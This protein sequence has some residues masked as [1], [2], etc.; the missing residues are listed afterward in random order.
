MRETRL[1]A[2][3]R[4]PDQR[5]RP[6]GEGCLF[7]LD[8]EGVFFSVA[9]QELYVFNTPATLLWCCVEEGL[10][11]DAII[12]CYCDAF[13]L[14]R[15]EAQDHVMLVLDQWWG[16]GYIE[17][18]E[19]GGNP[20]SSF[21]TALARVLGNDAM[22][23]AFARAPEET[24]RRLRLKGADLAA[25]LALDV[26][27]LEE[28]A[29]R[30]Q[31]RPRRR[32]PPP[33]GADT[34]FAAVT[35]GDRTVLETGV[36]GRLRALTSS[37]IERHYRLLNS[38]FRVRFAT[39]AQE[40]SVHAALAH[41]AIEAPAETDVLLDLVEN[42][43]GHVILDG[44]IPIS[45]C[46][47]LDQLTPAVK[48]AIAL[49]AINRYQFFLELHAGVVSNGE[50]CILLPG[51]SGSGKTTLTAGLTLAGFKYF[52]DEVALL[53]EETL[54]LRPFP[55]ALG[56]KRGALAAVE[57]RWPEVAALQAHTRVDGELVRYLALPR[58]R[59]APADS[60]CAA[61]WLIF[62]RYGADLATELRPISQPEALRRLMQECMV[63]P[64]SL[65]EAHV[66]KLVQWMRTLECY[67][68][69][70]SSLARAVELITERCRR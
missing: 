34:L 46:R 21:A 49:A 4:L 69:P 59:C 10:S 61:G 56:V 3:P 30:L 26:G 33:A 9:R 7:V 32:Q 23:T 24:A 8:D 48:S 60:T 43:G 57:E 22:R 6:T 31:E 64:Q 68:L 28:E 39:V 70:M 66:E 29:Q 67:E 25:F 19:M 27:A 51:A 37:P 18:P 15:L 14:S 63:L 42:D 17:A 50:R 16:L 38:T 11:T 12:Q 2:A 5:V 36:A 13:G 55:L 53:E 44:L 65:D 58:E 40:E 52:S 35:D 62:P 47:R 54:A 41:L 20:P 45:H 1:D